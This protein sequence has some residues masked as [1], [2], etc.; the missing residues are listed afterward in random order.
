MVENDINEMI[1][2]LTRLKEIFILDSQYHARYNICKLDYMRIVCDN[3]VKD[4]DTKF[5]RKLEEKMRIEKEEA[6]RLMDNY[7]DYIDQIVAM[8]NNKT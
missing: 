2:K 6:N 8:I 1:N 3:T 4:D 7:F 5:M